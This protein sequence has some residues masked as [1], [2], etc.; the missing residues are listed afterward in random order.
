[1]YAQVEKPK[2]NKS[3]AV[4]N[5]VTQNKIENMSTF[6]FVDNRPESIQMRKLQKLVNNSPQ[7]QQLKALQN[8][9][10]ANSV[11]RKTSSM[12][13]GFGFVDKRPD[14]VAQRKTQEMMGKG[15]SALEQQLITKKSNNIAPPY[16]LKS[17]I[18]SQH[19]VQR[20]IYNAII[21]AAHTDVNV[22]LPYSEGH[23]IEA[24]VKLQREGEVTKFKIIKEALIKGLDEKDTERVEG[25]LETS[26]KASQEEIEVTKSFNVFNTQ[27]RL[28]NKGNQ[29][30]TYGKVKTRMIMFHLDGVYQGLTA[31]ISI[32][33][34]DVI[35]DDWN[36]AFWE[37]GQYADDN[38]AIE[39][40]NRT[41]GDI[42]DYSTMSY[43]EFHVT[44][45]QGNNSKAH[46]FY[47]MSANLTNFNNPGEV[48]QQMFNSLNETANSIAKWFVT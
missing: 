18:A 22:K 21:M 29:H 1:M 14:A 19:V 48:D 30:E 27:G 20:N 35:K 7:V 5:S 2:G 38:A 39:E 25:L 6:Q 37:Q 17:G 36:N 10:I 12:K 43:N 4:A 28:Y 26:I 8:L 47:G 15:Y 23:F 42:A 32:F 40:A 45:G 33:P 13:Q 44:F 24:L 3:R 16:N 31:H 41:V 9:A 34:S 46:F 11:V